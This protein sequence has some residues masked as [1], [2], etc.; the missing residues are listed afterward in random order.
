MKKV[1]KK[2]AAVLLA[3]VMVAGMLPMSAVTVLGAEEATFAAQSSGAMVESFDV[4]VDRT[5]IKNSEPELN[6]EQDADP[7][8]S[9]RD[10]T[11]TD[12]TEPAAAEG[13]E[14]LDAEDNIAD[15][16]EASSSTELNS[17]GY[18][19]AEANDTET[20]SAA[21]G[22]LLDTAVQSTNITVKSFDVSAD[23]A[24]IKENESELNYKTVSGY[25]RPATYS[26][27][28]GADLG[29]DPYRQ[30]YGFGGWYTKDS[31]GNYVPVSDPTHF[32][33]GMSGDQ[34][35]YAKWIKGKDV[36]FWV[37]TNGTDNT[38][39]SGYETTGLTVTP[40]FSSDGTKITGV[41]VKGTITKR[42]DGWNSWNGWGIGFDEIG[43]TY[44]L[45]SL[46]TCYPD[47]SPIE[48]VDYKHYTKDTSLEKIY[49]LFYF[50][51]N[52]AYDADSGFSSI[53]MGYNGA[54]YNVNF[55][56]KLTDEDNEKLDPDKQYY[57][58]FFFQGWTEWNAGIGTVG[59]SAPITFSASEDFRYGVNFDFGG[60][61]TDF[62]LP[63]KTNATI[64]STVAAGSSNSDYASWSD[65]QKNAVNNWAAVVANPTCEGY[66]FGGWY[67]NA[68]CTGT[69][70]DMTAANLPADGINNRTYYAHWS[71]AT[72][73]LTTDNG[74]TYTYYTSVQAAVN[75]AGNTA[76]TVTML[77]DSTENVAIAANQNITL[78]LN[79]KVLKGTGNGSVISAP[80]ES[81]LTINDS[82]STTKHYFNYAKN[83]AWTLNTSA[84]SGIS[85]DSITSA[86]ENGAV[87]EVSGGVITGGYN[88][89]GNSAGDS[90]NMGGGIFSGGYVTMNGGNVIGNYASHSGGGIAISENYCAKPTFAMTGGSIRGNSTYNYGG[91][92]YTR[93]SSVMTM[94]GGVI[95]DNTATKSGSLAGGICS[96]GSLNMT[97]GSVERNSAATG[98]GIFSNVD[99]GLTIS[100]TAKI[101]NNIA[102]Q[103]GG[104]IW[105]DNDITISGSAEISGNKAA[106][107]GGVYFTKNL[108]L[109]GDVQITDNTLSDG[110]TA[111]NLYLLSGKTVTPS[112]L[113]TA[114]SIGVT[115]AT[116]PTNTAAV[117]VTGAAKETDKACF[118]GDN[119]DYLLVYNT[120]HLELTLQAAE[121]TTKPAA[122]TALTYTGEAQALVTAGEATGGTVQYS[123]DGT[124]WSETLPTGTNAGDYSVYAKVTGDKTHLDSA[125]TGPIK[126]TIARA[127]FEIPTAK[128][129]LVYNGEEQLGVTISE[130]YYQKMIYDGSYEA[131]D[132]GEYEVSFNLPD[133]SNFKWADGTS[134]EYTIEWSIAK[135]EA[136]LSV[137]PAVI[138]KTYGDP[139]ITITATKAG[140]GA[141][142]YAS[143]NTAV[144]AVD[145]S[146]SVTIAGAGTAT[147]T[148]SVAATTNYKADEVTL[149]VTVAKKDGALTITELSYEKTYGDD[150]FEIAFTPVGDGAITWESSNTAAV[151]VSNGTAHIVGVGEATITAT[152]ADG[153][154][155]KGASAT[156]TITVKAKEVTLRWDSG[157][158]TYDGQEHAPACAAE[159]L[160]GSDECAVTVTGAQTDAGTYTA[161]AESLSN[162]NYTLPAE[163]TKDFTIAALEYAYE[164]ET[165]TLTYTKESGQTVTFICEGPFAEFETFFMDDEA[166]DTANYTAVEG[167]TEV[168]L[169]NSYLDTLSVGD[170]T[171]RFQYKNGASVE[172]KL[173]V[174]AKAVTPTGGGSGTGGNSDIPDS[175]DS[176]TPVL[177]AVVCLLS[178][179]GLGLAALRKKRAK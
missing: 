130:S 84:T 153:A 31:G 54:T 28:T 24:F 111:N 89:N 152:M 149:Q 140:D 91:G 15:V 21:E 34:T 150:D 29:R 80:N 103:S 20:S 158:F 146:G 104:G 101:K 167:S 22:E 113:T 81:T 98:A 121:L 39:F 71:E 25:E 161:T 115:T 100:G 48:G 49:D 55:T 175:G 23:G 73:S 105:S 87:I 165:E 125:V 123:L 56:Y 3:A 109:S 106:T 8:G 12:Y 30:G 97:G 19:A 134:D 148:V 1:W 90:T 127:S 40:T 83:G 38:R 162:A 138:E 66:I 86:T 94:S 11:V 179:T 163:V 50:K 76:A 52:N 170:H 35:V 36:N 112:G 26:A 124:T 47:G 96:S 93:T 70:I 143:D 10:A 43:A 135:A 114:A 119:T 144:A 75:A 88:N 60:H 171:V 110:I 141:V 133:K 156:T 74:S 41:T 85:P 61:G 37:N 155:Y 82:G 128:E 176:A 107:A 145:Q 68:E 108:T 168:T 69:A 99:S 64:K 42:S 58:T 137:E 164:D 142:T 45:I 116:A 5:F 157:D 159:G 147:I 72:A 136:N 44:D 77:K 17:S 53:V 6:A 117:S 18:D 173:T 7:S 120:D 46:Y 4:E 65:A 139:T 79:G 14:E 126:V 178:L 32:G 92:I 160:I 57:A 78:D 95:S 51:S 177:W 59:R 9:D 62:T 169:K 166:V 122:N 154:N 172:G 63:V 16:P 27:E 67:D 2:L 13:V 129:N 174:K 102:S 131:T 132:A 118:T 151:T 33:Q